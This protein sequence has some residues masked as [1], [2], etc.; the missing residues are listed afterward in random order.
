M[1][2]EETHQSNPSPSQ[3][4]VE[5]S[6]PSLREFLIQQAAIPST[7][8]PETHQPRTVSGSSMHQATHDISGE[9][10]LVLAAFS[11]ID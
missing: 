2:A 3:T 7:F 9:S 6:Y 1:P 11:I 10:L 8:A 5:D 4:R